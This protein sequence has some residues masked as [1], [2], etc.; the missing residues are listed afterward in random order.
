MI[1]L[2][3]EQRETLANA[4]LGAVVVTAGVL[5]AAWLM[6][7]FLLGTIDLAVWLEG[8]T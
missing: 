3:P 4:F 2:S 1:R 5:A 8:L 6:V 7:A